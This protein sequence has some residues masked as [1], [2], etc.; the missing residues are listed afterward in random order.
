MSYDLQPIGDQLLLAHLREELP[1]FKGH[2]SI[3]SGQDV[4]MLSVRTAFR[5]GAGTELDLIHL[6]IP[7]REYAEERTAAEVSRRS[8][9]IRQRAY[10]D[11][12]HQAYNDA[13]KA[14]FGLRGELS[15]D[16]SRD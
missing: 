10:Q 14:A 9:E 15:D 2:F 3:D 16:P 12:Y 13:Y 11:A 6:P 8:A 5:F 7:G 1:G 4:A